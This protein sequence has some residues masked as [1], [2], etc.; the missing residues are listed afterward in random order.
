MQQPPH[1]IIHALSDRFVGG[2]SAT[3]LSFRRLVLPALEHA[4]TELLDLRPLPVS[5]CGDEHFQANFS[6]THFNPIQTQI[7]HAVVHSDRHILLGAP[8][9][10]GRSTVSMWR[11]A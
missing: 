9:G 10:S 7:F 3:T 2:D 11:S 4:H 8:T 1:Y 6:Y 5:A